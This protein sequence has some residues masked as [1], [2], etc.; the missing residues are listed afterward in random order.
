MVTFLFATVSGLNVCSSPMN[1]PSSFTDARSAPT[2]AMCDAYS[3]LGTDAG[4]AILSCA[5]AAT[6]HKNT[7]EAASRYARWNSGLNETSTAPTWRR[8]DARETHMYVCR[9]PV[10]AAWWMDCRT[11]AGTSRC[12]LRSLRCLSSS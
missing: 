12:A 3:A 11:Y 10:T 4:S 2:S 1:G 9:S 8:V 6:A 7:V 5:R